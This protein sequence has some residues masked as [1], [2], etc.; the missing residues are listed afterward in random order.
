MIT[1]NIT[2]ISGTTESFFTVPAGIQC[3]VLGS[4][5]NDL[6]PTGYIWTYVRGG[7]WRSLDAN[8]VETLLSEAAGEESFYIEEFAFTYQTASSTTL[9][10][11]AEG[12]RIKKVTILID[13]AFNSANTLLSV[14]HTGNANGLMA[15]T[16]ND[17]QTTG[18]YEVEP[19]F[20]Y[21]GAD[22]VT[23]HLTIGTATQGSGTV[24]LEYK[25]N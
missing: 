9:A 3:Q 11:V 8:G 19:N 23:F 20:L 14:G 6:P 10:T 12:I 21:S 18:Q 16:D 25:Q 13:V 1:K 4:V 7:L 17:P 2:N 22:T 5:P 15:G 24:F